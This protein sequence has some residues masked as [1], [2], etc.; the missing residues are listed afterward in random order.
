MRVTVSYTDLLG[1]D[2]TAVSEATE[3]VVVA[4]PPAAPQLT[5]AAAGPGSMTLGWSP[6]SDDGGAQLVGFALRIVGGSD[7]ER[8]I[9]GIGPEETSLVVTDLEVGTEYTFSLMA[10]NAAGHKSPY[11]PTVTATPVAGGDPDPGTPGD[12][13]DPGTPDEP[14]AN[15][16]VTGRVT[17]AFVK[18]GRVLR[19]STA[20]LGDPDGLGRFGYQWQ[21][22]VRGRY[23][24]ITGATS[25]RL[26]LG[27]GVRGASVRVV[28]TFTDGAGNAERAVSRAVKA[29]TVP[30]KVRRPRAVAGDPLPGQGGPG[31]AGTRRRGAEQ[32][33]PCGSTSAEPAAPAWPL[34]VR[35]RGGQRHGLGQVGDNAGGPS[36][37]TPKPGAGTEGGGVPFPPPSSRASGPR[38]RLRQV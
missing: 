14:A 18:N 35:G 7:G 37:L 5:R 32:G 11:S 22:A 34:P 27:S 4:V 26:R 21:R 30:G 20:R 9:D 25:R 38:R 13:G 19:A 23:V 6:P 2:E 28:V 16:P 24:D 8:V 15:S 17:V 3:P 10:F 1:T 33:G 12:P 31:A 29:P 36:A